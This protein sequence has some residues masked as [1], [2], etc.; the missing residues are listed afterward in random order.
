M[1]KFT[2]KSKKI[3]SK[4]EAWFKKGLLSEFYPTDYAKVKNKLHSYSKSYRNKLPDE[5]EKELMGKDKT[6]KE[7]GLVKE[8]EGLAR[9]AKKV[10]SNYKEA[11]KLQ[12]GLFLQMTPSDELM[13]KDKSSIG[14]MMDVLINE[15][16]DVFISECAKKIN[17]KDTYKAEKEN[18]DKLKKRVQSAK[19]SFPKSDEAFG[20]NII[21]GKWRKI[22]NAANVC[23]ECK[24]QE[25]VNA[26]LRRLKGLKEEIDQFK[27]DYFNTVKRLKEILNKNATEESIKERLPSVMEFME[28]AVGRIEDIEK[29][30]KEMAD[31]KAEASK[32]KTA[33]NE[34]LGR[35]QKQ[36][37]FLSKKDRKNAALK[38]AKQQL[39]AIKGRSESIWKDGGEKCIWDQ[40]VSTFEKLQ[41]KLEQLQERCGMKTHHTGGHEIGTDRLE[42]LTEAIENLENVPD[43]L[44]KIMIN[45]L[46]EL[47]KDKEGGKTTRQLSINIGKVKN[48]LDPIKKD[49]APKENK[50]KL[51]ELRKVIDDKKTPVKERLQK[52][53]EAIAEL[54]KLS[55]FFERNPVVQLYNTNPF[56]DGIKLMVL[57][58]AIHNLEI[59]ILNSASPRDT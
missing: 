44:K 29:G 4:Y 2:K 9:E 42:K 8:I 39:E 1:L 28:K 45:L 59:A 50:K 40:V 54:H 57:K 33:L 38:A 46:G 22:F 26:G 51:D 36:V 23:L 56:D 35:V 21:E 27:K 32:L 7:E 20:T 24:T 53:E 47:P 55:G 3:L 13:G 18:L 43:S 12:F 5:A 30:A 10:E 14:H 17:G 37:K 52:R 48:S 6:G 15:G 11:Q 31:K 58:G 49:T 19:D 41:Y 25:G 34:M 16:L